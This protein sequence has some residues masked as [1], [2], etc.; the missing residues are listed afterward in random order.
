[1]E[2]GIALVTGG[3]TGIGAACCEMLSAEGFSVAVHY[4]TSRETAESLAARLPNSFTIQADLHSMEGAEKLANEIAARD[5]NLAVLVN[6]AGIV[7]DNYLFSSTID[8]F[9]VVMNTNLR[10]AWYL[11]KRLSKLMMRRRAGR[12]INISSVIGHIGNKGQTLYGMSKAAL[13]NFTKSCAQEFA[14]YGILVNSV[15]PGFIDTE[16]TKQMRPERREEMLARIPLGRVGTPLEIAE[17]VK[18]LAI[19]GSYCTGSIIHANGG[20]YGG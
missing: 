2:R 18:F 14:S 1:M 13:D 17:I 20:L 7:R 6:N 8:E 4:N 3:G 15:A 16:M 19:S 9:E 11:T 5:H 12:I 10:A